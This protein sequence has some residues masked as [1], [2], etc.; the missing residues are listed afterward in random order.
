MMCSE[1]AE[2]S[3]SSRAEVCKAVAHLVKLQQPEVLSF[4]QIHE[5][6]A[7]HMQD[8]VEEVTPEMREAAAQSAYELITQ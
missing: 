5:V 4:Q 3:E 2:L 7:R 8:V 1:C 6:T